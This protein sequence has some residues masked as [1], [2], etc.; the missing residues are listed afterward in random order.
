MKIVIFGLTITS[1][2]GN[3]HARRGHQILFIEKDE[4][5]YRSHRDLASPEFCT[6]QLYT[7]WR[8]SASALLAMSK[9][10]DVIVVGSYFPDAIVATQELLNAGIGPIVFYDIDTP[11]TLAKLRQYGKTEYLA[12]SLIP[13][14][15]AYLSFCGGPTLDALERE[16]GSPRAIGFYCSVD[17]ELYRQ[18]SIQEK[19]RC[20]L[21]Y[22]GTY[23]RDRHPKLM[24]LLNR[25]A[26]QMSGARFLVAGPQYPEDTKWAGN[27]RRIDHVAPPEHASFYSS[28][29]FTLNLTR[30]DMVAAGHSPS[31]RL[32]EASACGAT[33]LS[34]DW[35]GLSEFLLPAKEI[36]VPADEYEVVRILRDMPLSESRQVGR[37]ARE[38]ILQHH[39]SDRRALEFESIVSQSSSAA[40][41]QTAAT[42]IV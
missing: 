27:V 12:A 19:F 30:Q 1:S 25:A 37:A 39:T 33:I 36:L 6:V 40:A 4:E 34:D 7:A 2:F 10:A 5:W 9:D 16:F 31:V 29:R 14:Y 21:S 24:R 42:A 8:E 18:T 38:R 11:V 32:F 3:G 35:S 23:A 20:D 17:A 41:S 15:A 28:G 26:E 22:L 13:H